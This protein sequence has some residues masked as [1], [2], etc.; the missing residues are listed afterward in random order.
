VRQQVN[1]IAKDIQIDSQPGL[2]GPL[3]PVA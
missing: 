2:E 3:Q 1:R